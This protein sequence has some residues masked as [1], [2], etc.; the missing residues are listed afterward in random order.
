MAWGHSIPNNRGEKS[1]PLTLS[2]QLKLGT[3]EL[4]SRTIIYSYP[5]AKLTKFVEVDIP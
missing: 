5:E 4:R 3:D 2:S 1:T